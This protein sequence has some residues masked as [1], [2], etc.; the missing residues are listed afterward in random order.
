MSQQI[1]AMETLWQRDSGSSLESRIS[2]QFLRNDVAERVGVLERDSRNPHKDRPLSFNSHRAS[3]FAFSD[4][5]VL[6]RPF[7]SVFGFCQGKH[8][9]IKDLEQ[10]AKQ[11][12]QAIKAL[13]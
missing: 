13:G 8:Q 2:E 5:F 7:A 4:S 9:E 12:E 1:R 6:L 3:D 11:I 10:Q